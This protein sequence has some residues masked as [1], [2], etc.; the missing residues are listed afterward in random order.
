MNDLTDIAAVSQLPRTWAPDVTWRGHDPSWTDLR[1]ATENLTDPDATQGLPAP[2]RHTV[3]PDAGDLVFHDVLGRGGMG[4]VRLAEQGALRRPVAVKSLHPSRYSPAAADLLVREARVAGALEHP[5]ILPLHDLRWTDDDGP[6]LVMKRIEG[7]SWREQLRDRPALDAALDHHLGVLMD[8]CRAAHFAHS[9]GVVHRDIKPENVMVGHYGE[10][11]LVDW[12]IARVLDARDLETDAVL[13]TPSYMAPEMV[14]GEAVDARTDVYL[15][16]ACLHEVLSGGPPHT[17][18]EL[19]D[20]L[21]HALSDEAASYA[22][23]VPAELAAI[24][25]TACAPSPDDRYQTAEALR[26]AVAEFLDHRASVDTARRASAKLAHLRDLVTDAP[27]EDLAIHGAFSACRF[28]FEQ[29]LATW[30]D[31]PVAREGLREALLLRIAFE[32]DA[33]NPRSAEQWMGELDD[34]PLSLSVRLSDARDRE[35]TKQAAAAR[36]EHLMAESRLVG[37]DWGRTQVTLLSGVLTG[38]GLAICAA[39]AP[40]PTAIDPW[41]NLFVG[42]VFV[43]LNTAGIL[44]FRRSLLDNVLYIRVMGV[45]LALGPLLLL[46]RVVAIVLDVGFLPTLMMDGAALITSCAVMAVTLDRTF[47]YS[48][49]HTAFTA[50]LFVLW[51]S[52]ALWI[53]TASFLTHNVYLA[54]AV[55]PTRASSWELPPGA[56]RW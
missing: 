28:G 16:G 39:R 25:R 17:G 45:M 22:E 41:T 52:W 34:V 23:D 5:N 6:L 14:R 15:L 46:H 12:G 49:L 11:Y 40:D 55:R 33:G 56:A 24:A 31:N 43:L 18:A 1:A 26:L 10:V 35:A 9:R 13:G 8:V 4:V 47:V 37:H 53:V 54:W 21:A 3:L 30:P 48:T 27:D 2:S 7:G 42:V 51:P 29:A 20:V 50:L 32:L 38:A 36:L 44:F 19:P